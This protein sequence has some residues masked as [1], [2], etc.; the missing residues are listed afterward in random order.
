DITGAHSSDSYALDRIVLEPGCFIVMDRGYV[1]FPRLYRLHQS[2]AYF[3]LRAKK[4]LRF[5]RRQSHRIDHT[6]GVRSDQTIVLTGKD[7]DRKFPALLRRV[8]FYA[9]DIDQRFV[10][11]TN[12]FQIPSPIVAAI[13]H[14]RWQ[15]E[16]FFKWIKQHLRIKRF[17]GTSPNA[18]KTQIWTAMATYALIAIAKK[19]FGLDHSL[20][21]ILQILST[22]LFEKTPVPLVFQRYN[23]EIS[24]SAS[25]NQLTLFEI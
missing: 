5:R 20:Y 14:Q 2:L 19:R 24:N 15:I 22:V 11:L 17:F 25:S 8:T 23:D 12:N 9:A 1:D 13:Y 18:V 4:N 7:A 6:T 16:L 21:T 10:F 3:V